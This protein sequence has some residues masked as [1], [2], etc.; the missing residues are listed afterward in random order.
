M[1]DVLNWLHEKRR[2]QSTYGTTHQA[3]S[4]ATPHRPFLNKAPILDPERC[5]GCG[6]CI[7]VCMADAIAF[8]GVPSFDNTRCDAC[9]ACIAMCPEDALSWPLG[10]R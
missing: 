6:A 7:G 3:D 10:K 4:P 2:R 9:G 8:D 1:N 5:T